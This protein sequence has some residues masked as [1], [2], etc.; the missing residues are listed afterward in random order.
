MTIKEDAR[1][2]NIKNKVI[3]KEI[4]VSEGM[5]SH[6]YKFKYMMP[7][8]KFISLLKLIYDRT[9]KVED[10]INK[11]LSAILHTKKNENAKEVVEW[12]FV[13]GQNDRARKIIEKYKKED[14]FFKVYDLLYQRNK[15]KIN[16]KLFLKSIEDLRESGL[17]DEDTRAICRIA[18]IYAIFD[19][20]GYN[21]IDFYT[22]QASL[23]VNKIKNEFIKNSYNQRILEL[24]AI[25]C[26]M[27]NNVQETEK[28]CLE[29]LED[30]NINRSPLHVCKMLSTLSEVYLFTSFEKSLEYN[31]K[32]MSALKKL[33]YDN[34]N[35]KLVL[36]STH[37]FIKIFYGDLTGLYLTNNTEKAHYYASLGGKENVKKSLEILESLETKNGFLS[38]FQKCYKGI[39]QN[40]ISLFEIAECEFYRRGNIFYSLF[41][42]LL[43]ERI[44]KNNIKKY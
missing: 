1:K 16:S 22:E 42:K 32:A 15:L 18:N 39:A 12:F 6:Y 2:R 21:L 14:T 10:Y 3:A 29:A 31:R 36:E 20:A 43:K 5:I 27:N 40:D 30:E 34:I 33:N 17:A 8:N 28:L 4:N 44:F 9:D 37:D 35:I 24:K 7:F 25:A 26:L 38:P 13:N 19:S 11:Y 23:I 41:P